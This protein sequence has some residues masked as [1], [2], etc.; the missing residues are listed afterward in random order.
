MCAPSAPTP[1]DPKET[2]AAQTG[3]NVATAVANTAMG[4]VNQYGPE[5]SLTYA[6]TGSTSF[7]D[8]YTNKTYG[9]PQYSA[10]T[11]LSPGQQAIYDQNQGAKLGMSTLANTSAN[12]LNDY[13][14][15]S[16][17]SLNDA[18]AAGQTP[19]AAN[20]RSYGADDFGD[21]RLR[22]EQALMDRMTPQL[23]RDREAMDSRLA[24]QGIGIGS[25]AYGAAQDD[26]SRS[27]N[28]ARLGTILA[29]GQEQERLTNMERDQAAF[30]NSNA[31]QTFSQNMQR[32]G[33]DDQRRGQ[34]LQETFAMRNQPINEITALLS[35]SQVSSPNFQMNIPSQMA[36]TDNAGLINQNYGQQQQNYQQQLAN[37]NGLT[38]GLFGL[39][40]AFIGRPS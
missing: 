36:T 21:D 37:W 2:T 29:G 20:F 12:K 26:Y 17:F 35:G 6:Q 18:P 40:S 1:P 30:A 8:P 33:M 27:V 5:G 39:G 16:N 31:A 13:L 34:T 11:T 23:E 24:N 15:S 7:T 4:N 14:G 19:D 25:R 10:T 38:G 28:D 3:T 22:V 9:I 32:A